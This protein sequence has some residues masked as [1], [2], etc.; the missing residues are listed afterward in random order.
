MGKPPELL[1]QLV[2]YY[3]DDETLAS[4]VPLQGSRS[5]DKNVLDQKIVH[6]LMGKIISTAWYPLK[7][8]NF[9]SLECEQGGTGGY[10]FKPKQRACSQ[11]GYVLKKNFAFTA[12]YVTKST[13]T[14]RLCKQQPM[15]SNQ[16]AASYKY[17]SY[18]Q[19]LIFPV[20]F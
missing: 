6:A 5:K 10:F 20:D 8:N 13:L 4:S 14:W 9:A 7:I 18:C 17:R 16:R 1:G 11:A 2:N 15:W 12:V 3:F 19:N